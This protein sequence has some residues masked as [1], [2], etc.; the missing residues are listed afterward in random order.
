ME[1]MNLLADIA[2]T[3]ARHNLAI[4]TGRH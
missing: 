4:S 1:F 2:V 3:T